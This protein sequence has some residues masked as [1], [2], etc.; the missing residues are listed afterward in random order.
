MSKPEPIGEIATV[1]ELIALIKARGFD[2][3]QK[4]DF[5]CVYSEV[6]YGRKTDL[7]QW[8]CVKGTVIA[9]GYVEDLFSSFTKTTLRLG[10][11]Q[12]SNRVKHWHLFENYL[13]AWRYFQLLKEWDKK[14][15]A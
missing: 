2:G 10:Y 14:Q 13:Y 6:D 12:F 11:P 15:A 4:L 7:R 5:H 3:S 1:E 9:N 8:S